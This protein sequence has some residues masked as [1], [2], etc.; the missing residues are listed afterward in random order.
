MVHLF[1]RTFYRAPL[2]GV[3][4]GHVGRHD[5]MDGLMILEGLLL[6]LRLFWLRPFGHDS[7]FLLRSRMMIFF[8]HKRR[9]VIR[10]CLI[11]N[12]VNMV[13]RCSTVSHNIVVAKR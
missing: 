7:R 13:Q 4:N 8:D 5:Y 11:L 3:G 1:R 10:P 12:N 2:F 6:F 9:D